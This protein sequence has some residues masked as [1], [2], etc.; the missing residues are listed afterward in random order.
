VRLLAAACAA[1]FAYLAVG[2]VTGLAAKLQW[3]ASERG[4][5]MS[6]RQLWLVQAG[7]NITPIRF[8][9]VSGFLGL[10]A[11]G[12]ASGIS[13]TF[14]IAVPPALVVTL[15]PGWFYE[16]RRVQRLSAVKQAWP[17]G[18]R[19]LVAAV[20]S[21]MSLPLALEDLA[22]NGPAALCEALARFS[23]LARVFG[24][25]AALEAVRD[26]LADPTT[27][28]VVEVLLV[29]HD[30]GGAIVPAILQDLAESTTRELRTVE[31]VRSESLEQRLS[32]RIVFA[33]PWAVLLLMTARDG[34]YRAF[35]RSSGGTIV[36][37]VGA[38]LSLLGWWAVS[39]LGRQPVEE[40][41]FG[42]T[43]EMRR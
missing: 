15:L 24:V 31:E 32:A 12:I 7:L 19:H 4:A 2:Y 18:L 23:A 37:F 43:A 6:K 28:R 36:I 17:D 8:W 9:A 25:P 33:V 5:Q 21:G 22:I 40:R 16:R 42:A 39:R 11:L 3:R 20:R 35:Y 26:E 41:V 27:D 1:L 14:W 34:P 29:A 13:Q 38:V 10:V 30:R